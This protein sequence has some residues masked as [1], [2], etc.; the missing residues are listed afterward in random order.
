MRL[1]VPNGQLKLRVFH[2]RVERLARDG[3]APG[4]EVVA[5]RAVDRPGPYGG[6][7]ENRTRF[8]REVV[9]CIRAEAPGLGIAVRVS[10]FDVVPFKPDNSN[11]P[12]PPMPRW[13]N[14]T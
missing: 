4:R 1:D 5:H 14:T 2:R 8:L 10:A 9:A 13:P 7:L 12:L 6:S 3:E 11:A